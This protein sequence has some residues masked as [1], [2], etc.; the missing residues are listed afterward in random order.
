M[1]ND[2]FFYIK[3]FNKNRINIYITYIEL[4]LVYYRN[5][6]KVAAI[7]I[8]AVTDLSR[9]WANYR[10]GSLKSTLTVICIAMA[11]KAN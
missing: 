4:L 2:I 11:L 10:D 1:V 8:E 7:N 9:D 6:I 5:V 3:I